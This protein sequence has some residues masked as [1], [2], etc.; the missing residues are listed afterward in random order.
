MLQV[1]GTT[2]A[3]AAGRPSY[4]FALKGSAAT[5]SSPSPLASSGAVRRLMSGVR[6]TP[7]ILRIQAGYMFHVELSTEDR[8]LV[9]DF[10]H[11]QL[12]LVPGSGCFVVATSYR[13]QEARF[14]GTQPLLLELTQ[15]GTC[16]VSITCFGRP[17]D[18]RGRA[19]KVWDGIKSTVG[20]GPEEAEPVPI[21]DPVEVDLI[22]AAAEASSEPL[23]FGQG[24]R[25][26]GLSVSAVSHFYAPSDRDMQKYGGGP[27]A[28]H[29]EASG[30]SGAAAATSPAEE[31]PAGEM[32]RSHT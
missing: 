28:V 30:T 4:A 20:L 1:C 32:R 2:Q 7:S 12:Q 16:R 15:P 13:L 22:A 29:E 26:H 3:P 14:D 24:S 27:A 6:T 11:A 18:Q 23:R 10:S 31:A 5:S 17:K 21:G 8:G 19:R 9:K 25:V